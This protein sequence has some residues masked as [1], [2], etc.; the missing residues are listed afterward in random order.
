MAPTI[1]VFVADSHPATCV[2]IRAILDQTTDLQVIGEAHHVSQLDTIS[3]DDPPDV[4]LIAANLAT[5]SL[6]TTVPIW[7]QQFANSKLLLMLPQA[8]ETCLQPL[9]AQGADGAFL[10]SEPTDKLVQAIHAVAQGE[11]WLSHP[12]WQKIIRPETPPIDFTESEK[13]MLPLI[14][15]EMTADEIAET[16][17]LSRRTVCRQLETICH[18]LDVTKRLGAAIQIVKRGLA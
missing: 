10:K 18:K 8:D 4:L 2:G 9:T 14:V 5:D 3:A 6:V 12:L 17:H 15:T 11:P 16:L 13:E 1:R 7:K